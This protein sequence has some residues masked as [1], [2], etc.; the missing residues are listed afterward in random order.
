MEGFI[1]KPSDDI[2]IKK[3]EKPTARLDSVVLLFIKHLSPLM[4]LSNYALI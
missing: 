1:F 4:T 2:Y 3:K